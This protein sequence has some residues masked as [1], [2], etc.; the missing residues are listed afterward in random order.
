MDPWLDVW[1]HQHQHQHSAGAAYAQQQP[2]P[3]NY[4][5][6]HQLRFIPAPSTA[7]SSPSMTATTATTS[8]SAWP[9]WDAL[10]VSHT[11]HRPPTI[12]DYSGLLGSGSRKRTR[13]STFTSS[14][15][16]EWAGE[17]WGEL[18]TT[19]QPP[20][21]STSTSTSSSSASVN[22]PQ[23]SRTGLAGGVV[24]EI[25]TPGAVR[26]GAMVTGNLPQDAAP[27][28]AEE[29]DELLEE[30][31]NNLDEV[32]SEDH[33]HLM[34]SNN[35]QHASASLSSSATTQSSSLATPHSH[36]R[37][38]LQ[39]LPLHHQHQHHRQLPLANWAESGLY[40]WTNAARWLGAFERDGWTFTP[41]HP[42]VLSEDGLRSVLGGGSGSLYHS[43]P[44]SSSSSSASSSPSSSSFSLGSA[45]LTGPAV[46]ELNINTALAYGTCAHTHED[47]RTRACKD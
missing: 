33:R 29:M 17:R 5:A 45:C 31:I 8:S 42:S 13:E 32:S 36:H 18:Y 24:G 25:V 41:L 38:Q 15:S 44:S 37:H 11:E 26:W 23:A 6:P 1:P 10:V 30:I 12:G 21:T 2:Q 27:A 34:L 4:T 3:H 20:S 9:G 35:Q 28:T 39:P 16:S 40:V 19:C 22:P 47:H 14:T 46:F 7:S 43:P